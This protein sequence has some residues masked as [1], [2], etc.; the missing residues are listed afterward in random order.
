MKSGLDILKADVRQL[1]ACVNAQVVMPYILLNHGPQNAYPRIKWPVPEPEDIGALTQA[2]ERLV[3]FGLKVSQ[4]GIRDKIGLQEPADDDDLLVPQTVID[5]RQQ[6]IP[7]DDAQTALN[8]ENRETSQRRTDELEQLA[9]EFAADWEPQIQSL[10]EPIQQ[11]L[12]DALANNE[13]IE[14]VL[15]RLEGLDPD[16][17]DTLVN[18]LADAMFRARGLGDVRD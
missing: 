15:E 16:L 6:P 3:P 1:A 5:A 9:D 2:V 10:A 13:S 18:R 4:K 14:Q 11:Q 12:D 8:R 7:P 17:K